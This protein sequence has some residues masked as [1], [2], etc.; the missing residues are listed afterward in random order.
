MLKLSRMTKSRPRTQQYSMSLIATISMNRI[1]SHQLI[2]GAVDSTLFEHY[3]YKTLY[4]LRTNP[5]TMNKE[6]VLLMDNARIHKHSAVFE[7]TER[8]RVTVLMNA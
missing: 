7:M 3:L 1:I 2:E 4:A 6:V 8:M 5:E